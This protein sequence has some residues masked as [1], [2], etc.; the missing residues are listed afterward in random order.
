MKA[1]LPIVAAALLVGSAAQIALAQRVPLNTV[2]PTQN[3]VV[4][5]AQLQNFSLNGKVSRPAE[6]ATTNQAAPRQ[7][8]SAVRTAPAEPVSSEAIPAAR[9][10][11]ATPQQ[12]PAETTERHERPA[13][14]PDAGSSD[15]PTFEAQ[16]A[17]VPGESDPE[18]L[19]SAPAPVPA[20]ASGSLGASRGLLS[21]PWLL[22][23]LA[24]AGAAGWFLLRRRP[25]EAFATAGAAT[26]N[27]FRPPAEPAPPAP[28]ARDTQP[29][30]SA[31]GIVSTRLRPW[32]DIEFAPARAIVDEQ[33]AAVEF[34]VSVFNSG[35]VPARDV[36]IEASLFN[37]GPHQDQQIQQFFARPLGEGNPIP[38]IAPLQRVTVRSAVL[39]PREQVVPLGVQGRDLFVP[40]VA[41]S[42]LYSW[43]GGNGQTSTSYLV[44]KQTGAE[45]LAPLRLDLGPRLFRNLAAREHEL[46]VRS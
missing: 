4:G 18:A 28:P 26:A 23:A 38:A 8:Q 22:A 41:L 42:A 30:S 24:L 34:E 2:T 46:R 27:A 35:S 1:R 29:R 6:P 21:L 43:S 7:R 33:K 40:M 10:S 25:R 9:P 36:R 31:A 5:P 20:P 39:L 37:A 16:A 11:T 32:L 19:A 17:P 15:K 45:K 44:G 12:K 14:R 13:P 3:D